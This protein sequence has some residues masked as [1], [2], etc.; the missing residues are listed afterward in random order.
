MQKAMDAEDPLTEAYAIATSLVGYTRA[1]FKFEE[2]LFERHGYPL[3][4]EHCKHHQDLVEEVKAVMEKLRRREEG[5]AE[6]VLPF[7]INWLNN[8]ILK[9]DMQ[10]ADF[11]KEKGLQ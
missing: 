7:L 8:H 2:T 6:E 3:E 10:Y 9:E 5:V 1:H 11:F 4:K